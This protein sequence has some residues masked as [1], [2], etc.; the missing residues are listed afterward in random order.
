MPYKISG[1]TSEN[2]RIIIIREDTEAIELIVDDVNG[3]YEIDYLNGAIKTIVFNTDI[4]QALAFSQVTPI[5]YVLTTG[6][7]GVF[8]NPYGGG[9]LKNMDY[10][11]ISSAA[12]AI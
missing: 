2:S 11:R 7:T 5:F 12:N 4:G 8:T 3:A 1:I 10:I 6:D 9:S